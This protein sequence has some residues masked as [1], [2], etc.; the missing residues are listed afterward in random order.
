MARNESI[1]GEMELVFLQY[2]GAKRITFS[3]IKTKDGALPFLCATSA[4]ATL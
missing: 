3:A 2:G 4:N 1:N